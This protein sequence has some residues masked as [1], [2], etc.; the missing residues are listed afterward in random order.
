MAKILFSIN[1]CHKISNLLFWFF[2]LRR[3]IQ[4]FYPG[5]QLLSR[6]RRQ[7]EGWTVPRWTIPSPPAE[8]KTPVSIQIPW[9]VQQP[10]TQQAQQL[11]ERGSTGLLQQ[12]QPTAASSQ[13][14]EQLLPAPASKLRRLQWAAAAAT[15]GV[16]PL[17][18]P[19]TAA[20]RVSPLQPSSTTWV[21]PLW[22]LVAHRSKLPSRRRRRLDQAMN[23]LRHML[24]WNVPSRRP[25]AAQYGSILPSTKFPIRWLAQWCCCYVNHIFFTKIKT[26]K[27]S[28]K[29]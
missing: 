4:G 25:P 7:P 20:V 10:P 2:S 18:S 28:Q 9:S 1:Y 14:H 23:S 12:P 29:I 15:A 26:K 13:Q 16:R 21:F 24:L 27:T 3:H 6:R 5:P 17:R 11:W 8:P 22:W 19:A